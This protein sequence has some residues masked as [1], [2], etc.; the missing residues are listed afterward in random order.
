MVSSIA[1][2]EG[3]E[4]A[5]RKRNI[6]LLVKLYLKISP[7]SLFFNRV[8]LLN[9][10]FNILIYAATVTEN[11]IFGGLISTYIILEVQNPHIGFESSR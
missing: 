7:S 8:K 11:A 4:T 2:V 6:L 5:Q 3:H 1:T 9:N 10:I